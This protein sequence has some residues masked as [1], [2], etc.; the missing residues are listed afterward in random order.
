MHYM[1]AKCWCVIS[2]NDE[3]DDSGII[4]RYR[5]IACRTR[6]ITAKQILYTLLYWDSTNH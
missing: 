1:H 5:I 6:K 2:V 3:R 4:G